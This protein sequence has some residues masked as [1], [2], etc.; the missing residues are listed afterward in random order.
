MRR[1]RDRQGLER[2]VLFIGAAYR[3]VLQLLVGSMAA[4]GLSVVPAA[5]QLELPD[6]VGYVNDFADV[7]PAD[8]ERQITAIIDEVRAKS[9]GGE[10]AVVT[11]PS[12]EGRSRD[13]V[14]LQILREWGVGASGEPGDEVANTGVVVL[15][16]PNERVVR[17]ELG[18]GANTFITAGEAG[19]IQDEYML[20]AFREADFG[21]GILHGV[22]AIAQQFAERFGFELTGEVPAIEQP[23]QE[24][25]TTST[26]TTILVVSVLAI[27]IAFVLMALLGGGGGGNGGGGGGGKRRRRRMTPIIVPFPIGGRGRGGFGG[28]FGGGLGGFGGGGFGGG[29]FGGFGGG[30]GGGGG[31]GRGW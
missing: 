18:Y 24:R 1:F 31:A 15:V 25:P 9:G 29:G 2:T 14:A 4:V 19:R 11:L 7:I 5:A 13:E 6:P 28:G 21:T 30:M 26:F 20:P 10:I 16:A 27:I 12:L 17:L 23:R 22:T 8:Q 3:F